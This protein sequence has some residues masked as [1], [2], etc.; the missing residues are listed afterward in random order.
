[1]AGLGRSFGRGSMTNHW[2]DIGNASLVFVIGA[3][4]SEN[5]PACMAHIN[6]AKYDLHNDGTGAAVS[7]NR[8]DF[9]VPVSGAGR[10]AKII[11]VDPRKTRT[12]QQA[13]VYVRIRPGT[14]I[15]FING[16]L[17]YIF[18]DF[19][20]SSPHNNAAKLAFNAWHNGTSI[21][22]TTD[23]RTFIDDAGVDAKIAGTAEWESVRYDGVLPSPHP[24]SGGRFWPKYTD[25]RHKVNDPASV[26]DE[27][28]KLVGTT[29]SA[30][31]HC[32]VSSV[33][34]TNQ[35]NTVTYIAGTDYTL[36]A[37]AG[38]I[39]RVGSGIA[40]GATVHVSY[41][42]IADDYL[43]ATMTIA[44]TPVVRTFSNFPVLA[45]DISEPS[46]V[47]SKLRAHVAPYTG[48][49]VASICGCNEG[50]IATVAQA[51]IDNSR[52]ADAL[53]TSQSF[54]VERAGYKATTLLYAMGTTQ[55]TNGSQNI[56]SYAI[57]Q[58]LMGNMGRPGGGINALRGIHNV[59][60]STD[61][62]V[63]FDLI[64]AYSGNPTGT[65]ADYCNKLFGVRVLDR[66]DGVTK[67][68]TATKSAYNP[69]HLGMQQR[70]FYN[71]TVEWFGNET[72]TGVAKT[73][74]G[75]SVVI[76]AVDTWV[77][78][79]HGGVT[80]IT[81]MPGVLDTDW[82]ADL[83]QGRVRAITAIAVGTH[84]VGY[85]FDSFD[86]LWD[87]WPKGN[88]FDHI[89]AFRNMD[90]G[91]IKAAVVWGQNPAITE[92]N[93]SFV[94]SGLEKLDTLVCVDMFANETA[95]CK[96]KDGAVT[97]LLPACSHV[98]EAGSVSNSGRWIQWRDRALK[99][100]GSSKA[101][102]ELLL[103]L[104]KALDGAGAF[105]HITTQWTKWSLGL[106]TDAYRTL[107]GDK[108]G[109]TPGDATAF[110]DLTGYTKVHDATVVDPI[111]RSVVAIPLSSPV[112]YGVKIEGSEAV[113]EK[114]FKEMAQPGK[115][116]SNDAVTKTGGTIWIYSGFGL[117]SDGAAASDHGA[118]YMEYYE[119]H[120]PVLAVDSVLNSGDTGATV[121]WEWANRARNRNS[122]FV[123]NARNYPRYG[124]A[125]LLNRRV[126]YNNGEFKN[127]RSDNFVSPGFLAR[128]FVVNANTL[129]DWTGALSYRAYNT[130]ADLAST[131][132]AVG[133]PH[134]Y[135]GR[136]PA[137]GEPTETPRTDVR[138]GDG[139]SMP[140][141]G[142]N[143]SKGANLYK[144][145]TARGTFGT[146][147]TVYADFAD[148]SHDGFDLILT[149][150]R[151]VE[152]F[153]GGP[154]TRNNSW[155]VEAEP[156]PWI[157]INS[158]DAAKY[159]IADGDWVEVVTRRSNST[160]GQEGRSSSD[161]AG[162][163]DGFKAR[164]GVGLQT[165]QRVGPGLVAIPW[166]WGERGLSTGS[167]AND[168]CIDSYDANTFI[169]EFKACLC[170]IKKKQ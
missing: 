165:N 101:D 54:N 61:M 127:D 82:A 98:E 60:G 5:H 123:G 19:A 169:P 28:L 91:S 77:S 137:H 44:A 17:H 143:T 168:L 122:R 139:A 34:V 71:M 31:A 84:S 39:T 110:E 107:Y 120:A 43:R 72:A 41:N 70:G 11:V 80:G 97:Y 92:P 140:A 89:T 68:T 75:E 1:V 105:N 149:T 147:P 36:D 25:I 38:T 33:V 133:T 6:A 66:Y 59:Q 156:V 7:Y 112:E 58:T 12:A 102:L 121:I 130:L 108:Y 42:H 117:S 109:W 86:A 131:A 74:T 142:V 128:M 125:W 114:I 79:K 8:D 18:D 148:P 164:V 73:V 135:S 93:Q 95:Q 155:N 63:L 96:R 49:T 99:P 136:F 35:A 119:N 30:L 21:G 9:G 46:T 144:T 103:R 37:A 15:A 27:H 166:H 113:A 14:D 141:F 162:F 45:D 85:T 154:I 88:G 153:Q 78:L 100:Q 138:D 3:N 106:G 47:F 56:R 158:L 16:V 13:D 134:K 170:R 126:Q 118:A 50:D 4:P 111:G 167:R 132:Q 124:W 76:G 69:A 22:S 163:A 90:L 10:K 67:K 87:L 32:A 81:G 2:T 52:F 29:A 24:F 40:D 129:A 146:P 55:H 53:Y 157:E 57:L 161:V 115:P 48:P 64:P 20:S 104:A 26:A 159:G 151:C 83:P 62:G 145:D 152:H 160:S 65:Y 23:G 116:I 150:I 94:R 51:L